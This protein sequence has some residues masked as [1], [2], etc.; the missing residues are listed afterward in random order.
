M[1]RLNDLLITFPSLE[2]GGEGA[3]LCLYSWFVFVSSR[4]PHLPFLE[5]VGETQLP[6]L[7]LSS[8]LGAASFRRE[9][10]GVVSLG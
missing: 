2:P 8:F 3:R 9:E 10:R 1:S 5:R 6:A 7:S 4:L